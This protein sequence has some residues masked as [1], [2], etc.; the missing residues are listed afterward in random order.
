MN[1]HTLRHFSFLLDLLLLCTA[2]AYMPP[3]QLKP[4]KASTNAATCL[5]RNLYL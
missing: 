4:F 3:A 5:P 1:K 2:S